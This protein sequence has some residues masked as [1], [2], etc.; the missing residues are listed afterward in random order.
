MF[1]FQAIDYNRTPEK[2]N[3]GPRNR[4]IRLRGPRWSALLLLPLKL[5][6]TEHKAHSLDNFGIAGGIQ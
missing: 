3:S 2:R 4:E 5:G 1:S 6:R